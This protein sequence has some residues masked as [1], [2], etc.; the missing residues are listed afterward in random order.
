M[1]KFYVILGGDDEV[2][3]ELTEDQVEAVQDAG[4]WVI[5]VPPEVP[6]ATAADFE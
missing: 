4:Y 6:K 5:K 2:T 1:M 3:L